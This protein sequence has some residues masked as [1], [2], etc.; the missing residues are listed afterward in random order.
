MKGI[1]DFISNIVPITGDSLVDTIL[2]LVIGGI[3]F[4][5]AW[6]VAGLFDC[7]SETKSDIHW[8]VRIIVFLVLLG[9]VIGLVWFIR[10]I[11]SIPWWVWI[12]IGINVI[13]LII[14]IVLLYKRRKNKKQKMA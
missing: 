5:I 3:A 2:F 6:N 14:G 7:D 8:F 4:F 13:G 12:I 10:L 1:L 9:L 11:A